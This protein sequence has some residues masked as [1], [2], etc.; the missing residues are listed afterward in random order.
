VD[1]ADHS[2]VWNNVRQEAGCPGCVFIT[3]RGAFLKD[4]VVKNQEQLLLF[5]SWRPVRPEIS[6]YR[7]DKSTARDCI[8]RNSR[9]SSPGKFSQPKH[10]RNIVKRCETTI[11]RTSTF[12]EVHRKSLESQLKKN[13]HEA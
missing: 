5:V 9:Q 4:S 12:F 1:S 6:A 10:S 2:E 13:P 3:S 8:F 7:K 11:F